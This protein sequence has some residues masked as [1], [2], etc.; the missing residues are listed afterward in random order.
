MSA[1]YSGSTASSCKKRPRAGFEVPDHVIWG[2]AFQLLCIIAAS[3]T[4]LNHWKDTTHVD[5]KEHTKVM[6]NRFH[7]SDLTAGLVLTTTAVLLSSSP[8]F[9]LL[10]NY[11][12]PA[13]YILALAAFGGAL[14]SV[15]T[16]AAVLVIY[17]TTVTHKDMETLKDMSRRKVVFLLVWLAW[18]SVCLAFATFCLFLSV[19]IACISTGNILVVVMASLGL[20]ALFI[21]GALAIDVVMFVGKPSPSAKHE[22]SV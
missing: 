14:L 12:N 6:V 17:E 21:N 20:F 5:W 2:P 3:R 9:T 7:Y 19:F 4:D 16:G 18:P 13:S 1:S 15:I 11:E 8:P 10:M 22:Q